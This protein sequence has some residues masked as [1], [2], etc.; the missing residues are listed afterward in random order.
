M[1]VLLLKTFIPEYCA[2]KEIASLSS[3]GM[4]EFFGSSQE[5]SEL[6]MRDCDKL[7]GKKA[8]LKSS[9]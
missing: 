6:N 4:A 5:L 8:I 3:Q 7:L 9:M 2:S 1:F